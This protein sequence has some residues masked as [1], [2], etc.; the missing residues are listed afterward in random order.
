MFRNAGKFGD[1]ESILELAAASHAE[2]LSESDR[3]RLDAHLVSCSDCRNASE[4]YR[5]VCETGRSTPPPSFYGPIPS[6]ASWDHDRQ[7]ASLLA[8]VRRQS[9]EKV[10]GHA[11][12]FESKNSRLRV[13]TLRLL[14]PAGTAS[15]A[16]VITL[17]IGYRLGEQA[18]VISKIPSPRVS[19]PNPAPSSSFNVSELL[20]RKASLESDLARSR[21]RA[22]TLERRSDQVESKLADLE[23]SRDELQ[24]QNNELESELAQKGQT[25]LATLNERDVTAAKLNQT[26]QRLQTAEQDL[27]S[28]REER[29]RDLLRS[30]SFDFQIQQLATELQEKDRTIAQQQQFLGSDRDIRELMGARQLYIADVVDVDHEGRDRKPFGR[31]FYTKGKSLIFYAFDLD[32]QPK[33][34]KASVFQLWG[35]SDANAERTVDLG[36]FYLDN[37]TNHRWVLRA[38]KPDVLAQIDAVFVTV[39]PHGKSRQPTSKPI[40]Y[41]YL[42][43]TNPNHP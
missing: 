39:E 37:E 28:L 23:K 41:T 6:D 9:H 31:L 19:V 14:V 38:D 33:V 22:V 24:V 10:K 25:T 2:V 16:L 34:R 21:E 3:E 18:Q 20:N 15:I 12:T 43:K 32:Q 26:E 7:K 42:R 8:A 40:L 11:L 29:S 13:F 17:L 36:I 30:A 35:H 27:A 4:A 1:H 5:N